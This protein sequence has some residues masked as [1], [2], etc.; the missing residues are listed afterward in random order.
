MELDLLYEIDA[1]KP[2]P[3]GQRP[4]EQAAFEHAIEEVKLA[5][6]LP[7]NTVWFVEHHFREQRSH[8]SAPEVVIG[9]LTQVTENVNLGFGVTLLPHGYIHPVRVA[10]RVATADILS[11]GRIQFGT[12]RSTPMEMAAFG[13]PQDDASRDM[14]RDALQTIIAAWESDGDTFSWESEFLTFPARNE[15]HGTR[16]VVPKPYQV[17]HPPVWCAGVSEKSARSI[18]SAGLGLLSLSIQQSTEDM[19]KQIAAYREAAAE[20]TPLTRVTTNRVAAYTLVHCAESSQQAESNGAWD[21]V[22]WWYQN[23]AETALQW[24]FREMPKEAQDELFPMLKR[25]AENGVN[26]REFNDADMIIIGDPDECIEKM[27]RYQ[28]VGVDQLMCY[29]SFGGLDTETVKRNYKLLGEVVIPELK[30]RGLDLTAV[31]VSETPKVVPDWINAGSLHS[32]LSP[33]GIGAAS[34]RS[35]VA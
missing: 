4:A 13:V 17:P 14:W 1:P 3:G 10:E 7:F 6:T 21:A 15:H 30:R 24:D 18:G 11:K 2:W 25:F 9:A 8:C 33:G 27:L 23:F 20:P 26:P 31:P 19:A 32:T 35:G 12:G 34:G 5:D 28:A 16:A 22:W 29:C